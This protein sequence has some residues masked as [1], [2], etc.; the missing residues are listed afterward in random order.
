MSLLAL[1][2]NT[3]QIVRTHK[4]K[5]ESGGLKNDY[6]Q[7]KI[8][9]R[10][11]LASLSCSIFLPQ[12]SLARTASSHR[13]TQTRFSESARGVP[14]RETNLLASQN[15]PPVSVSPPQRIDGNLWHS[16]E[17]HGLKYRLLYPANYNSSQ[18]YPLVVFLHGSGE[19]GNDNV[20]QI[21]NGVELFGDPFYRSQFP[22]FVLAPQCPE[23]D[24][25]GGYL[26]ENRVS[27][28]QSRLIGLVKS[29][30]VALRIDAD[31]LLLTGV[32]MGAI[33]VWDIIA[34]HPRL[35]A[36]AM[37]IAGAGDPKTAQRLL[38]MPIWAFH[39][40]K[41]F[42]VSPE[43]DRNMYDLIRKSGGR[44]HYTEYSGVGHNSWDQTFADP[45]VI[46]WLFEQSRS[47]TD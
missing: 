42:N 31:R 20:S 24:S 45:F 9:A 32:S 19:S 5:L 15:S 8:M 14:L 29:V 11:L 22:A 28:S 41:D 16:G 39:G 4:I 38:N 17:F 43:D 3:C 46:S 44:M 26:Y 36:A 23:D 7:M 12:M 40:S 2:R 27:I 35:F 34:R 47:E 30:Q 37:P 25:W 33:G 13:I 1:A 6:A 18:E 10:L 21:R